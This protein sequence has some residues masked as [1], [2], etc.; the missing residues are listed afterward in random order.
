MAIDLTRY[1]NIRPR[2]VPAAATVTSEPEDVSEPT[3]GISETDG[4]ETPTIRASTAPLAVPAPGDTSFDVTKTWYADELE[5]T[6]EYGK[7]LDDIEFKFEQ[8][9]EAQSKAPKR[10]SA[11]V[12]AVVPIPSRG[13]WRRRSTTRGA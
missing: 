2:P 5:F 13:S 12:L 11:T 10:S 8:M 9:A 3:A 7:A 4:S 1:E 6:A